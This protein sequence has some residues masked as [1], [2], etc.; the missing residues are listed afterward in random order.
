LSVHARTSVVGL[1]HLKLIENRAQ[2]EA[3]VPLAFNAASVDD[4]HVTDSFT[5]GGPGGAD[6]QQLSV[7]IEQAVSDPAAPVARATY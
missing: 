6:V 1:K 5:L 2:Q 7:W 3:S 4:V